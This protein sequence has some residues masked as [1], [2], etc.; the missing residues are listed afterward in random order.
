MA[1]KSPCDEHVVYELILNAKFD[2]ESL[3]EVSGQRERQYDC[4]NFILFFFFL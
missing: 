3:H 2:Q 4:F 1:F